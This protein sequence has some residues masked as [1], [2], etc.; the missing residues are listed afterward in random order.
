[1]NFLD[2][3][4]LPK[5][6][7]SDTNYKEHLI[8]SRYHHFNFSILSY[9]ILAQQLIDDNPFLYN[10]CVENHLGWNR[11]KERLLKEILQQDADVCL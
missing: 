10:D 8:R 1:M 3:L 2:E 11:R 7:W 6:T 5:R 9:N 4:I